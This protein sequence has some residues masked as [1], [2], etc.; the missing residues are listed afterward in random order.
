MESSN[1]RGVCPNR[2]SMPSASRGPSREFMRHAARMKTP[3]MKNTA[4]LPNSAK[5]L[6]A[7]MTPVSGRMMM[8]SRR[9]IRRG[10]A[11]AAR[12]E[13][14]GEQSGDHEWQRARDPQ[15]QADHEDA[16]RAEPGRGQ[17][18][19]K[20]PSHHEPEEQGGPAGQPR[21]QR[22][23]EQEEPERSRVDDD[24]GD[25]GLRGHGRGT[26]TEPIHPLP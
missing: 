17:A 26:R 6:L 25:G 24:G 20:R 16:E 9:V 5:A 13:N 11:L 3:R 2:R 15:D 1:V 7:G 10:R 23:L 12:G 14:D 22:A 19:W 21:P 18:F 4:S 8:A